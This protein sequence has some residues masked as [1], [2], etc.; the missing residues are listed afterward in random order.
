MA[1]DFDVGLGHY[2]QLATDQQIG[3]NKI[4]QISVFVAKIVIETNGKVK[5]HIQAAYHRE[6]RFE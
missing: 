5:N 6:G 3:H 4:H 2:E 1:I